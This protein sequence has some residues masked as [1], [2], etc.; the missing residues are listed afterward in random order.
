[1]RTDLCDKGVDAILEHL[2]VKLRHDGPKEKTPDGVLAAKNYPFYTDEVILAK[3]GLNEVPTNLKK[4]A[5]LKTI[6]LSANAISVLNEDFALGAAASL[7]TVL[8]NANKFADFP[9]ALYNYRSLKTVDLSYNS[10]PTLPAEIVS[11]MPLLRVLRLHHCGVEVFPLVAVSLESLQELD[12][13]ENKMTVLP[14]EVIAM[15]K[16]TVLDVSFNG[17][18]R[19]PPCISTLKNTLRWLNIEGNPVSTINHG[20]IQKGTW[21]IMELLERR[22]D[23]QTHSSK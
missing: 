16:L 1:M 21:A 2:R 20:T 14:D 12:L 6:D 22:F 13:G 23:Q 19:I 10:I 17:I 11:K 9:P 18:R 7:E 3:E 5:R 8:L 15:K 4:Y